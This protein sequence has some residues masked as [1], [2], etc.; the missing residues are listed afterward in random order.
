MLRA[1]VAEHAAAAGLP[2]RRAGDLVLAAHEIAANA[3]LHGGGSATLRTWTADG[4][5]LCEV[6]DRGA[7]M[8][9]P[10]AGSVEPEPAQ[11]GGRGLWLARQLCDRVQIRT[12]AGGTVVRLHLT[13]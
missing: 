9:D 10:H 1:A 2:A 6:A 4:E 11:I 7:G 3:H 5:F 8:T 12:G 13:L